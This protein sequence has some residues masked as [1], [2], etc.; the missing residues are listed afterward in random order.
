MVRGA[1]P[2]S[3]TSSQHRP[4]VRQI[5]P[6]YFLGFVIIVA[7]ISPTG[8]SFAEDT[9]CPDMTTATPATLV[10]SE[11]QRDIV[12]GLS[13]TWK[14][15]SKFLLLEF[16]AYVNK[17]RH[18]GAI[19]CLSASEHVSDGSLRRVGRSLRRLEFEPAS[20]NG[21]PA[22]VYISFSIIGR[23]TESGIVSTLLMNQRLSADKYG[24]GYTAPQRLWQEKPMWGAGS[25]LKPG[26][27][28]EIVA[29]V[30]AAGRV[31]DARISR[32]DDGP[33]MARQSFVDSMKGRCFIPG[34]A[35]GVATAMPFKE[36]FEN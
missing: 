18:L 7:A 33:P 35:D 21:E 32:W 25:M 30:D 8:V 15:E 3:G 2:I 20:Y 19:C 13:P 26:V 16:G 23:K 9:S 4:V 11:K 28:G 22:E 36:V 31:T 1:L 27:R 29:D 12:R 10:A 6:R 34:M 5:N 17:D 24:L 14:S